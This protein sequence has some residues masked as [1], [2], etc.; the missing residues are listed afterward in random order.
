M[1]H[2]P[3][4]ASSSSRWMNCPG[5]VRRNKGRK[6]TTSRFASEGTA[7][8]EIC[9]KALRDGVST[10]MIYSEYINTTVRADGIDFIVDKEMTDAVEVY[11]S[12]ILTD[13]AQGSQLEIEKKFKL[14]HLHPLLWGTCDAKISQ[15]FG[16]LRVYD[17]K[18][19]KGVVVEVEDNPQQ[20]YYAAG[21]LA[22]MCDCSEV[23]LIIV[24]PRASH[25]DGP[26]RRWRT[27]PEYIRDFGDKLQI[28]AL[29]TENPEAV[30]N[31][32]DW[33]GFCPSLG[34]CPE[35]KRKNMEIAKLDFTPTKLADFVPVKA[36]SNQ[37]LSSIL[38]IENLFTKWLKA[39]A[40]EA[41]RR[42]N[43]GETIPD[44]KL[45][46]SK[47]NRKY[48]NEDKAKEVL[49]ELLGADAFE[50]K[51]VSITKAE[52][53]MKHYYKEGIIKERLNP[54][55]EKP[56]GGITLVPRKDTRLEI[57]PSSQSDFE[58]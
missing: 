25:I 56:L 19:G 36:L 5:S 1:K 23:E 34:D 29:E 11:V 18:Y 52:E 20:K 43:K 12:T 47:T 38:V 53:L 21:A 33:C 22:D 4:G 58:L 2:S 15:E 28:A 50:K 8:H 42:A 37:D 26:V 54:L 3:L 41:Q 6:T 17:F 10:S 40:V 13:L 24:Q 9:E 35:V 16:L 45:V 31:S 44:C 39:V 55:W 49:E 46:R 30:L 51:I 7:A 32:G 57:P 14:L 48:I 27:T